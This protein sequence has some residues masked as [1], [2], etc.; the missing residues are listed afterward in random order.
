MHLGSTFWQNKSVRNR[1]HLKIRIFIHTS[2][3]KTNCREIPQLSA[4]YNSLFLRPIATTQN[5]RSGGFIAFALDF[6][7]QGINFFIMGDINQRHLQ[8]R[9]F[10]FRSFATNFLSHPLLTRTPYNLLVATAI[11]KRQR[12]TVVPYIPASQLSN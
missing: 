10:F 11:K 8:T 12:T 6:W 3:Y 5:C 7:I 2:W 1:W 4:L 9:D